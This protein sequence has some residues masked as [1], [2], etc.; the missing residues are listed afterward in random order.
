MGHIKFWLN[1]GGNTVQ[2]S[3]R[4]KKDLHHKNKTSKES[5]KHNLI[6]QQQCVQCVR[7]FHLQFIVNGSKH[8][9]CECEQALTCSG[10]G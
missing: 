2:L 7:F 10:E 4:T 3:Y 8:H 5:F 9:Q 1:K 6:S